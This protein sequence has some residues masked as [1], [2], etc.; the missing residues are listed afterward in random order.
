MII[1]HSSW[2]NIIE[3]VF[4][5]FFV[6]PSECFFFYCSLNLHFC[7]LKSEIEQLFIYEHPSWV[8]V[9]CLLKGVVIGNILEFVLPLELVAYFIVIYLLNELIFVA[10]F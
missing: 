3:L 5:I 1:I 8:V 2:E 10:I 7:I 9:Y 6:Y 4:G